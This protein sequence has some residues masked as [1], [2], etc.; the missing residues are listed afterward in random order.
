MLRP[1]LAAAALALGLA[2]GARA[3]P[4]GQV[5]QAV[6]V[7]VDNAPGLA[8]ASQEAPLSIKLRFDEDRC[9]AVADVV[10][11]VGMTNNN[12]SGRLRGVDCT[13]GR[14]RDRR[15]FAAGFLDPS[16]I[17]PPAPLPGSDE[18]AAA[19]PPPSRPSTARTSSIW[20]AVFH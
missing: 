6:V 17:A 9:W 12:V 1:S 14:F 7:G 19:A 3:E 11:L 8:A 15:G 5:F 4:M 13:D 10:P 20:I 16:G 2:A 18:A